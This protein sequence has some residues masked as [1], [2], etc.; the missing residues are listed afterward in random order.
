VTLPVA[1]VDIIVS[2]W[3]GYFLLFEAMLDSVLWAR[4]HYLSDTGLMV[5]S[6]ATL[7]IAPI[8]DPDF[9]DSHVTFW[10][11]VYG[12]NMSSMVKES[13]DQAISRIIKP[14]VVA[15]DSF[16]FLQLDL[17]KARTTDLE[18]LKDFSAT[19]NKDIDSLD[20]WTIWFDMFFMPSRQHMLPENATP[21][22]MI[23]NGLVAFTTGPDG[24]DTHW[25]QGVLL[26]DRRKKMAGPL[27]V[28]MT[29][30]GQIGYRKRSPRSRH[31]EVDVK[32]GVEEVEEKGE[33]TWSID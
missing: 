33:Q 4:D 28:G 10:N 26:V 22:E 13:Y 31:L 27:K 19:L 15:A 14:E 8:H 20:A 29:V 6:H 9:V 16:P 23:K 3:M 21:T 18:F 1:K 24:A 5:P 11:S 30:R 25:K 12:F 7:R 17:H 2:E 32:W